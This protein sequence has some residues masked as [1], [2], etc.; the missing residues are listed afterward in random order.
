[1]PTIIKVPGKKG[2]RFQAKVRIKGY[3]P[4]SKTFGTRGEAQEWGRNVESSMYRGDHPKANDARS[5]TLREALERYLDEVV[6]KHRSPRAEQYRVKTLARQPMADVTL[7][8]LNTKIISAWKSERLREVCGATVRREMTVLQ[9][10]IRYARRVLEIEMKDCPVSLV[11]RPPGNPPRDRRLREGEF[12]ALMAAT[13]TG[14]NQYV[15]P[16]IVFAIE[17][18]MRKGELCSLEWA[19]V[20]LERQTARLPMTK[21]GR[22]RVVPL[23]RRACDILR[24]LPHGT[25]RVFAGLTENSLNHCWSRVVKRAGLE[26]LHFHD[27]RH[28]AISRL[29]EKGLNVLEVAAISGHS[30]MSMLKRYTHLNPEDIAA[31]LD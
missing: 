5:I 25:G 17:T 1:M 4:R 8:D 2:P 11:G 14:R 26:D 28:E 29:V 27:L 22:P 3:P 15:R 7:F 16:A 18:A 21:N 19:N 23:S 6:P 20:S 31:K 24:V 13:L 30:D 9:S 10:T 12:E